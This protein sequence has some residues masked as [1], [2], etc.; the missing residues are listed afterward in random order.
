MSKIN[1]VS[2]S[3]CS[4]ESLSAKKSSDE[5]VLSKD[6]LTFT[7]ENKNNNDDNHNKLDHYLQENLELKQVCCSAEK[8][9]NE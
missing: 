7:K 1:P 5:E 8:Y 4:K 2:L 6:N 9:F 3:N